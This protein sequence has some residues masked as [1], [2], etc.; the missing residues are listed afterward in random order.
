MQFTVA[1]TG[2]FSAA[3][4][5]ADDTSFTVAS[6]V[7]FVGCGQGVALVPETLHKSAPANVVILPLAG[8]VQ[9]VTTALAWHRER[10][11]ALLDLLLTELAGLP[12]EPISS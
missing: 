6:Q 12:S 9:V 4:R 10:P 3:G 7:A 1:A 8:E 5:L 11:P 2:S